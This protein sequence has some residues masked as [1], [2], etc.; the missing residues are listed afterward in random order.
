MDWSG[1]GQHA[2][3]EAVEE[4]DIPLTLEKALGHSA[5]ALVES[6]RCR[7]IRLARKTV[8]VSRRLRKEEVIKEV[9][10][11]QRLKH[12]HIIR[13]VGTYT[14]PR[15]LSILLYPV[16][17]HTLDQFLDS[18]ADESFPEECSAR[19][20]SV[21]TFLRCLAKA[22]AYIHDT[23]MKHMDIKPKNLLVRDMRNSTI[24]NQGQYKIYIADFGI[25]RSYR[26]VDDCN[27][28]SPTAYTP[29]YA[30]PEVVAQEPRDQK[31]DIFSL[32]A[33]Y[34]E[35]LAVLA[36]EGENTCN[37]DLLLKI[38]DRN[39]TDRSYQANARE[40][41]G[42]LRGLSINTYGFES[43]S[44]DSHITELVARMLSVDPAERPTATTLV[45]NIPFLAFCCDVNGGSEPF[46]AADR[47]ANRQ[48]YDRALEISEAELRY[49]RCMVEG[50]VKVYW[51]RDK[52]EYHEL[53]SVQ[54]VLVG[55]DLTALQNGHGQNSDVLPSNKHPSESMTSARLDQSTSVSFV[56]H[57]TEFPEAQS[58][59]W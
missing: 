24:C 56:G 43:D 29:M 10:H 6:V 26:S 11:L 49:F 32:G 3:F 33:V 52:L 58:A 39:P 22:V 30:A 54:D 59:V 9:E 45:N 4:P 46:E 36:D 25:A 57:T 40:I 48:L 41:Q 37:M 27:T 55:V 2:E 35:M 8:A 1:R 47:S 53:V 16:A 23:A 13:V 50:C 18:I 28:G 12:S 44:N 7:R 20:Y 42:W 38:R 31:A 17:D 15:K 21:S 19:L 34:A 14:L 5:S 51:S